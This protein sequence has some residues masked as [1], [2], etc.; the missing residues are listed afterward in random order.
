MVLSM[1]VSVAPASAA[2]Q[3]TLMKD[4]LD[5][6]KISVSASHSLSM[7]LP[8]SGITPGTSG[9]LVV[10]YT[11][12]G[13][14]FAGSPTVTCGAGTATAGFATNV[15]T[16]TSGVT[17][18]S[19]TLTV[20]PFTGTNPS[21]AGSKTITVATGSGT[22]NISGSFAIA[23]VTDDQVSV[24]ASIDP[25]ITFN[26]GA[27]VAPSSGCT[28]TFAGNGGTVALGTLTTLVITSSDVSSINHICTRVSTNAT[29]GAI[30]TVKSANASLKSTSTPGDA[31]PSATAAMAAGTSNYG[32]CASAT[33]KG[34]DVTV[35]VGAD[36]TG[37][38][39]FIAS[40][41]A[42]TAAG[43]VGA[44]TTAAQTVW[45]VTGAVQNGFYLLVLKAA[46]SGTQPAH[47]DYGDTLTF[48][49]TGTF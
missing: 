27:Q 20:S 48:V 3:P 12:F 22:G 42:D 40:C 19:G 8:G 41:A 17:P 28:G 9:T 47:S 6:V 1:F 25:S 7:T 5:R 39:P 37:Q 4:T 36:P 26:V 11:N 21:T 35:P 44:L 24:T 10:T 2:S 15:L 29:S 34:K 23:I 38:A 32:L 13:S 46:I 31:I 45:S 43:S 30:V 16:L 14:D 49:A 18:C 33:V